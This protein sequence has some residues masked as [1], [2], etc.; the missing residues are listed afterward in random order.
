MKTKQKTKITDFKF[1]LAGYGAYIVYYQ[2]PVTN[3][4]YSKRVTDMTIIDKTKNADSPMLK[5]MEKL[6]KLVKWG[7]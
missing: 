7:F 5:D 4:N 2:S 1:E 3:K 6:K